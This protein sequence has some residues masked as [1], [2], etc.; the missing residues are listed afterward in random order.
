[1]YIKILILTEH[2]NQKKQAFLIQKYSKQDEENEAN[3]NNLLCETLLL[4]QDA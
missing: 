4:S 1:M 2:E 3:I